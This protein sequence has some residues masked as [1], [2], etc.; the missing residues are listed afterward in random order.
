MTDQYI[1]KYKY[2]VYKLYPK[3]NHNSLYINIDTK[4]MF[5]T[6][7]STDNFINKH[8]TFYSSL[9]PFPFILDKMI[10]D[11]S[12]KENYLLILTLLPFILLQTFILDRSEY[13]EQQLDEIIKLLDSGYQN[14]EIDSLTMFLLHTYNQPLEE[15]YYR[16]LGIL[17]PAFYK[18]REQ[19]TTYNELYNHIKEKLNH[20]YDFY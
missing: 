3:F 17:F 1:L 19:Y 14:T 9:C 10:L 11:P 12:K 8:T 16:S 7:L 18:L 13:N 15:S 4:D 20:E 5:D 2:L 6:I